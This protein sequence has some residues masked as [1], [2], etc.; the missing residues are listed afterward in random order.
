MA[1]QKLT[2][3]DAV[4]LAKGVHDL[5][6]SLG[7]YKFTNWKKL[8]PAQRSKLN[9]QQV[10]LLTSS[11]DLVTLAVGIVLDDS[12]ASLDEIVDATE[13]AKKAVKTIKTVKKVIN[14]ATAA[15]GLAAAIA[16]K[17]P[18]AIATNTAN[19][20]KAATAKV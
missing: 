12:Q 11:S 16:S 2:G 5:A 6:V 14:V 4:A 15:V 17:D 8:T 18:G 20:V 7:D 10:S 19:L 13:Q 1:K 9:E 3:D